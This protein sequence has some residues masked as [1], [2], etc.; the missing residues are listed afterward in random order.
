MDGPELAVTIDMKLGLRDVRLDEGK[1]DQDGSGTCGAMTYLEARSVEA[2]FKKYRSLAEEYWAARIPAPSSP[3]AWM[4]GPGGLRPTETEKSRELRREISERQPEVIH[5]AARLGVGVTGQSVPAAAVGGPIIPFNFL[6]CVVD[7][8]A[9]HTHVSSEQ[10]LDAIDHCIG[11][12]ANT[13]RRL[14]ARL[15]KPWCW[16]VDVPALI[17]GWPFVVMRKAGVPPRVVEGNAAQVI[18]ALLTGLLWLA[19]FAYA[20]L[21][22]GL[23]SAIQSMVSR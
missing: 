22:T 9:G 1:D 12:A 20:A 11:A 8:A 6:A 18:K 16:L 7:Q 13:K 17:V 15:L 10:V 21:Q 4:A 5:W 23:L 3:H 19:G 2:L 14:L